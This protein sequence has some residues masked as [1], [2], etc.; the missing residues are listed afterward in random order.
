LTL[1]DSDWDLF[2]CGWTRTTITP[3]L[4]NIRS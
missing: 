4:D 3:R 1:S 2:A